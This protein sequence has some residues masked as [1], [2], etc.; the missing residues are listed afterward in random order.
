MGVE[1]LAFGRRASAPPS[2]SALT[3]PTERVLTSPVALTLRLAGLRARDVALLVQVNDARAETAS[4]GQAGDVGGERGLPDPALSLG[5]SDCSNDWH[6]YP[7]KV[8]ASQFIVQQCTC[9][10]VH[11]A[12]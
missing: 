5:Y 3:A 8:P 1:P 4:S 9:I 10:A 6:G 2:M 11:N 12:P 7:F